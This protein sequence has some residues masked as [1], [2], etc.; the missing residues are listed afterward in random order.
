MSRFIQNFSEHTAPLRELIKKHAVFTWTAKHQQTFEALKTALTNDSV[1]SYFNPNKPS[2]LWVDASN[3]SIGGILLQ[4]DN[5]SNDKVVC[6]ISRSLTETEQKYSITEKEAL[7]V[8]WSIE[9]L[10][11]YLYHSHFNVIVDHH[12]LQFIFKN[13]NRASPRIERWQMKLQCYRFNITYKQ[14]S[15]NIADF[16][17]RIKNPPSSDNSVANDYIYFIT[18]NAIPLA[19]PLETIKEE[20]MKD[21]NIHKIKR[22]LKTNDWSNCKDYEHMK[23]ELCEYN[24]LILRGNRILL[25]STL[26]QKC[27]DIVHKSCLGIVKTKQL[28]RTKLYWKGMDQDIENFIKPC[29]SCQLLEQPM[30]ESPVIMNELPKAPWEKI[31]AD[32]SSELPTGEKLLVIIDMFSKFPIIEIMKTTTSQAVTNRFTNLF[33]LFGYPTEIYTDNGP[34][35][36]S[37]EFSNYLRDRNITHH[38][39]IPLW[40]RSN[41]QAESFMKVINKTIRHSITSNSNIKETLMSTLLQYRNCPHPATNQT[42]SQLFLN[43]STNNGIP[44]AK[45]EIPKTNDKTQ[46]HHSKYIEQAKSYADKRTSTETKPEINVGDKVLLKRGKKENKFQ[47]NYFT[48]IFTVTQI[49]GTMIK[50]KNDRTNQTYQRHFTFIKPYRQYNRPQ[51]PLAESQNPTPNQQHKQY[52][53]RNRK[54]KSV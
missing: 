43:R 49:T 34:P 24:D 46:A 6:Y 15:K 21:D 12:P 31:S 22:A 16:I 29:R 13:R 14:G 47:S 1:V 20:T 2:K 25:P 48:D 36:E 39:S 28:L 7:A 32:F 41:G 51:E 44:S 3:Y 10:H 38:P 27:F 11:I 54:Q 18:S 19:I 9:K 37:I 50:V 30:K 35:W 26:R 33:S 23:I 53:L 52:P 42:P 8:V 45:P 40:P 5:D 4:A 17:S